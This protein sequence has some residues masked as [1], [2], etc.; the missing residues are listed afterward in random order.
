ML[1]RDNFLFL[2]GF[3]GRHCDYDIPC[4]NQDCSGNGLC[5]IT[6]GEC[7]C[8]P[9]YTGSTCDIKDPCSD[10]ICVNDGACDSGICH[11]SEP[12]FGENCE[13]FNECIANLTICENPTEICSRNDSGIGSCI[14]DDEN[15]TC[16]ATCRNLNCTEGFF[17]IETEPKCLI[18][19]T[20]ETKFIEPDKNDDQFI[21]IEENPQNSDITQEKPDEETPKT[22]LADILTRKTDSGLPLHLIIILAIV[23]AILLTSIVLGGLFLR[24]RRRAT[25]TY[26]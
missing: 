8:Y 3:S 16:N 23:G 15:Y 11:C 12:F 18:S 24:T 7:D 10:V 14:C 20:E 1:I 21:I 25:G 6:T 4:F 17:C 19:P 9:Y 26:R 5:N 2:D 22:S 13:I